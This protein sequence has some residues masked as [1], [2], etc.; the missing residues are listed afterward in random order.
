MAG[1][2]ISGRNVNELHVIKTRTGGDVVTTTLK[3]LSYA[4]VNN[5]LVNSSAAE[6]FLE[7]TVVGKK[8]EVELLT[9][10]DGEDSGDY[11][12]VYLSEQD[13]KMTRSLVV[14]LII[15]QQLPH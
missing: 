5:F 4:K 3:C 15:V 9:D 8:D 6:F 11:R 12:I 2:K 13:A 10:Y 1:T 14:L 7:L